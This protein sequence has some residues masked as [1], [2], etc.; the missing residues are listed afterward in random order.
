MS[1]VDG[2]N[3]PMIVESTGG[4]GQC[5]STGCI[6][7]LNQQCLSELKTGDGTACKN[8]CEASGNPGLLLGVAR[9][10]HRQRVGHFSF[11][12]AV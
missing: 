3:L 11:V 1:L 9:T 5:A 12:H 7:D 10:I 4:S 2:Y 8:A 6:S